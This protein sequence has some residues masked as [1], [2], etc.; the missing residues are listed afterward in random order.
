MDASLDEEL[1]D[2][3]ADKSVLHILHSADVRAGHNSFSRTLGVSA[4][5]TV[6]PRR[7]AGPG[8]LRVGSQVLYFLHG[9]GYGSGRVVRPVRG[10][11]RE[12]GS[13]RNIF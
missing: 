9:G 12:R 6:V 5:S 2:L 7:T 10:L 3:D 11:E 4:K 8:G 1:Q 13:K